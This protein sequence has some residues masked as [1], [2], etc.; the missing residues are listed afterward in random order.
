MYLVDLDI[1]FSASKFSPT[2]I[3]QLQESSQFLSEDSSTTVPRISETS[4]PTLPTSVSNA[5]TSPLMKKL[6]TNIP[7]T[8]NGYVTN[9]LTNEHS[10]TSTGTP[11]RT[12]QK[13]KCYLVLLTFFVVNFYFYVVLYNEY[14]S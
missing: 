2:E 3:T 12:T 9:L 10:V 13:S 4:S 14:I 6:T 11:K 7:N 8:S 5:E 1:F